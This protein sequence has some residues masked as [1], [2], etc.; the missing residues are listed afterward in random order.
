MPVHCKSR[1]QGMSMCINSFTVFYIISHMHSIYSTWVVDNPLF[2][3]DADDEDDE[4]G[5]YPNFTLT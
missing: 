2:G 4:V 1:L 5:Y 3:V